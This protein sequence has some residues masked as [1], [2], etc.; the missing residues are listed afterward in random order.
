MDKFASKSIGGEYK[1]HQEWPEDC[2]VQCGGGE[3]ILV[4]GIYHNTAFFE[5]FPKDPKTFIR[6]DGRNI[7]EAE[8]TAFAS[9]L[10]YKE[11][12]KHEYKR[13]DNSEHG[14]CINCGMFSS[15]CLAPVHSC[16]TCG[17]KE[18]N[19][20]FDDKYYCADHF[21]SI[22][23]IL[24]S[25]LNDDDILNY[26]R[27]SDYERI[28]HYLTDSLFL[29]CYKK[30]NLIDYSE[31]E[32][33]QHNKIDEDYDNFSNFVLKICQSRYSIFYQDGLRIKMI[34]FPRIARHIFSNQEVF[35]DLFL[36]YKYERKV[37]ESIFNPYF[38]YYA[39]LLKE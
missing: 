36:S 15:N 4:D 1:C 31:P 32:Y 9:Y 25:N 20:E 27:N 33:I 28:R 10:K 2:Y 8:A 23:D 37:N 5:A 35:E 16:E 14:N 19:Y 7:E 11:C 30:Y 38:D 34:K 29:N 24:K 12:P 13:R 17:K 22:V 6:G 26:S 21:V 3:R 18:I 39:N